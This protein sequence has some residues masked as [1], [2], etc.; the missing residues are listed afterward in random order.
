MFRSSSKAQQVRAEVPHV[1]FTSGWVVQCGVARCSVVW[2]GEWLGGAVWRGVARRGVVWCGVVWC[3]VVWCGVV[4]CGVVWCGVAWCGVVWCGVV[5][6]GVAWGGVGR[7]G[8]VR[9]SAAR[10]GAA[11]CDVVCCGVVWCGVA[12]C[13]IAGCGLIAWCGFSTHPRGGTLPARQTLALVTPW[14][15]P[16]CQADLGPDWVGPLHLTGLEQGF[17]MVQPLTLPVPTKRAISI[18]QPL[19]LA[20]GVDMPARV[21]EGRTCRN[22]RLICGDVV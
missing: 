7:C 2:C 3:G 17:T 21:R 9:R 20:R 11:R 6:C 10:C 14:R 1:S 13:G 19:I 12:W 18:N 5:W 8:V 22:N 16:T 15:Y 4:W